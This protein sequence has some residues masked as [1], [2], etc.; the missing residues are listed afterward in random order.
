MIIQIHVKYT[1]NTIFCFLKC[2]P[3]PAWYKILF[4]S[5]VTTCRKHR[6]RIRN[7]LIKLF[8]RHLTSVYLMEHFS[9]TDKQN[10][11]GFARRFHWMSYHKDRLTSCVDPRK[12]SE[13]FVCWTRIK[14]SCRL[15]CRISRGSVIS[16]LATAAL[17]FW[18][19]E[20]SYGYFSRSAEI[21]SSFAIGC[22]FESICL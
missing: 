21:P 22:S 3:L 15:I 5:S 10:A 16:A 20:I 9:V 2:L 17:C 7:L 18:P 12:Q 8:V 13:Q 6:Q 11:S 19:P 14:R 4:S 1:E